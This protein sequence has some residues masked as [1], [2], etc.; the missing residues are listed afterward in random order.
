M[1]DPPHILVVD[2]EP[3]ITRVLRT[4]LAA[5]LRHPRRQ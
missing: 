4:S 3:Q 2:D 5:R 1:A